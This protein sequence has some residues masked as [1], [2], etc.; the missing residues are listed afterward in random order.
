M[1]LHGWSLQYQIQGI[2]SLLLSLLAGI[3]LYVKRRSDKTLH[4]VK[5]DE[6]QRIEKKP[7]K[8]NSRES[9][10]ASEFSMGSPS[11][12]SF[13]TYERIP[14]KHA[15]GGEEVIIPVRRSSRIR[16]HVN[17]S[18]KILKSHHCCIDN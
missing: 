3:V 8:S 18:I 15:S 5:D 11:Y 1:R 10:V 13:T 16:S 2:F 6:A 7:R 4:P 12:G 9:L 14:A 17:F